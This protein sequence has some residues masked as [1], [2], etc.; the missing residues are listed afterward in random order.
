MVIIKATL[1]EELT[2]W[3]RLWCWEGL[4]TGGEGDDRGWD[5]WMASLTQWTWVWVNSGSWW[6]RRSG[7][8][9]FMGLQRVRHDW[10]TTGL[11]WTESKDST[12]SCQTCGTHEQTISLHHDTVYIHLTCLSSLGSLPLPVPVH[13]GYAISHFG[14]QQK[15]TEDKETMLCCCCF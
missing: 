3:K 14:G 12:E 6:T 15:P 7:V 13:F 1:C 11:N 5:D 2:H 9:Q 10:A 8:M 4:G